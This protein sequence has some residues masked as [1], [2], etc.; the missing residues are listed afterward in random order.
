MA[1]RILIPTPL[2]PFAD[3]QDVVEVDGGTVGELLQALVARYGDLRRHL[4]NDDGKLRSFVN[5]YVNDEDIRHLDRERTPLKTGDTISIVPSVAGGSDA[6]VQREIPELTREEVQR[7]SR[8]LIMPE[9]GMDG[10]R[11]LKAGSVVCIGAGG[12][13]SPAAMYLA[14]A[15]IGTLGI[16]DFDTVDASNL[17]RQ[18]I[19]GTSDVGRRKLEAS[20]ERIASLNPGVKVVEHETALT[21]KNALDILRDYDVVLDGTDNFQTRYLVNDACVL[22]GKPNAYGSI[23]RFD[24][25]ASVFAVKGGPCY[26]CLYP[27]PPPPG[28]VPS[29]AEGGVLGVLPGIIGIIQATEAI[30][31]ILGTGQPLVGRL[32]LYDALQ[33]RFREL[34]LR[35]DPDCPVCGDHPTIRALVDYD[36]FCGITPPQAQPAASGVPEVTVE[37]LKKQLDRGENV[38]VLDVREPNEYQIC[39]I[40][41]SKLIP[42]GDLPARVGELDRDRD[43]VVHCKMGGRSAKAVALLQERGFTRVRNLKGGILAWIDRVDPTQSK[44]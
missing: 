14:A 32:L 13:G 23:F 26:R 31:L 28:L 37:E 18:I 40:A 11:K 3:R 27:E 24:G 15:G 4:Y 25:Q 43:L 30:K 1:H 6:A 39:K 20:G 8:H 19:Y 36:A 7:Y 12:L 33:M 44:Y 42:L 10:Q 41:G 29:C 16:V 2:R 21:S 9:V 22:L 34:K 35:R 5:V 38:F 17:H